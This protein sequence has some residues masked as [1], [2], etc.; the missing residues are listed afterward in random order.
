[1]AVGDV[2]VGQIGRSH[3][4]LIG[5]GDP[6]MA[7][8]A[9]TQTLEDFDGVFHRRFLNLD[10]L[11]ATLK[12]GVLLQVLAVLVER[13]G[14]NGLQLTSGQH[15]LEDG[16]GIDGTLGGTGT[17][18]SVQLVDEQDDVAPGLDLFQDLLQPLLEITAVAGTGNQGAQIEG[19]QLLAVQGLGNL[20]LGDLLG[21][22]LNDGGLTD[23]RFTDE[24][25][26]VLGTTGQHLHDPLSLAGPADDRIE[27]LLPGQ[28]RQISTEL[29]KDERAGLGVRSA[30]AAGSR[31][32]TF[33][34][35]PA[36]A[37]RPGIAGQKLND[38]L[39]HP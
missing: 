32:F 6:M 4:G 20:I 27:L 2:A 34:G 24:H 13:G 31:R 33:A 35:R 17:H 28:L 22:T 25:R 39:T 7:F 10:R 3:Q 11:E 26:I 21:Q 8:V 36:R 15:G 9:V 29:I 37:R 19:V 12:G 14:T 1:M 16:S 18:Q 38:L 23:T 30:A 5:D